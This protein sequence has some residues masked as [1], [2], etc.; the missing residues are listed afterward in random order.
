MLWL[1]FSIFLILIGGLAGWHIHVLDYYEPDQ[2]RIRG[3][4]RAD[5]GQLKQRS[6]R[7]KALGALLIA[8]PIAAILLAVHEYRQRVA[9]SEQATRMET[10]LNEV[11][12]QLGEVKTTLESVARVVGVPVDRIVSAIEELKKRVAGQDST[13]REQANKLESVQRGL[14]HRTFSVGETVAIKRVLSANS[15]SGPV[16]IFLPT[17]DEETTDYGQKLQAIFESAGWKVRRQ[18]GTYNSGT[19]PPMFVLHVATEAHRLPAN[20]PFAAVKEALRAAGIK[21][22][23]MVQDLNAEQGGV[24]II[25]PVKPKT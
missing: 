4:L 2:R 9:T 19:G 1:V 23:V 12:A 8:T 5:E 11:K 3:R 10:R 16:V 6:K 13:I 24:R 18:F 14:A 22:G 7:L 20:H 17:V 15:Q 25:P 21:F